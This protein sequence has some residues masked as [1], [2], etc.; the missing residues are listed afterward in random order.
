V[1]DVAEISRN[2]ILLASR[3]RYNICAFV[4][5]EHVAQELYEARGREDGHDV[6][7]WLQAEHEVIRDL[8]AEGV[9]TARQDSR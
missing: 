4:V 9:L 7:H 8:A 2:G 6:E 5:A 3:R 1:N